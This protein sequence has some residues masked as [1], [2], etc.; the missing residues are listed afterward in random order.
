[1]SEF[2]VLEDGS[3]LADA[4]SI[5]KKTKI[6]GYDKTLV[7]CC[8]ELALEKKKTDVSKEMNKEQNK[9]N[10]HHYFYVKEDSE[11]IYNSSSIDNALITFNGFSAIDTDL[12]GL[13]EYHVKAGTNESKILNKDFITAGYQSCM[14]ISYKTFKV[15]TTTEESLW[16]NENY[17]FGE[18]TGEEKESPSNNSRWNSSGTQCY[19]YYRAKMRTLNKDEYK[20]E[21][22]D[23]IGYYE[24]MM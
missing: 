15:G 18:M 9:Y 11:T 23:D 2:Y 7:Q 19:L 6:K 16:N 24:L 10:S 3:V 13:A 17:A 4:V 5:G 14:P 22:V 20:L 1:M 21:D 8:E 12:G